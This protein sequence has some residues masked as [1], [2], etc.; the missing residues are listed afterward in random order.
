M[1]QQTIPA[2]SLKRQI[3]TFKDSYLQS[4]D[5][6]IESQ[7]FIGGTFVATFEKEFAQYLQVKHVISCNSGTDAL[8]MALQALQLKKNDI[9]LTTPF[10]FIAS[11]SEIAAHEAF[12]VFIDIEPDTY[13]MSPVLLEQWLTTQTTKKDGKLI[14]KKTGFPVVGI[15]PVDLFGQCADFERLTQI[16]KNWG[17]WIVEDCAQATGA[18]LQGKQAGT[19]GTIG[20]FS[21]YPTKN[22]GAFGDG[23]CCVTDDAEL[24]E[25]LVVIRNHGRKA[26][27]DYTGMGINSR[28]DAFQAAVLSLRLKH[29]DTFNENRRAIADRYNKALSTKKSFVVPQ[30][31]I[32]THVYHQYSITL[33]GSLAG[34]RDVL[35][36]ALTASGVQTRIFYPQPLSSIPFLTTCKE[37]MTM[38]PVT[39]FVSH[40]VFSLPMWPELTE[41]EVDSII[42]NVLQQATKLE[43]ELETQAQL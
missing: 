10:S 25:R 26:N 7:Q 27:Y 24:A 31:K 16:A 6:V 23:G 2:F 32:G 3:D 13:N 34:K 35:C 41:Q 33:Q 17:L 39:D 29:L 21:F 11:S 28:L 8:W 1:S 4:L 5:A 40:N 14:H 30:E 43:Q 22:L 42:E 18:T 38:C 15:L 9:V 37:L 20:I 19:I 12:P 36:A